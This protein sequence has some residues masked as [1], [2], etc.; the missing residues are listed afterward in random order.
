MHTNNYYLS[1]NRK[2]MSAPWISIDMHTLLTHLETINAPNLFE[3]CRHRKTFIIC[4]HPPTSQI[5]YKWTPTKYIIS[6]THASHLSVFC[7]PNQKLAQ[8]I[9]AWASTQKDEHVW[10][11][12]HA[13]S[14]YTRVALH[15]ERASVSLFS[16]LLN[17]CVASKQTGT[18][19]V[20]RPYGTD[21]RLPVSSAQ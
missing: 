14:I 17:W 18:V 8:Q 11:G 6:W 3:V 5:T 21:T 13:I 20:V 15:G 9:S 2:P 7:L 16:S 10:T 1:K 19:V 12:H 4:T